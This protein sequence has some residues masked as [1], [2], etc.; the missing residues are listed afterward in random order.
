MVEVYSQKDIVPEREEGLAIKKGDTFYVLKKVW[1][2]I[3]E[4]I[5]PFLVSMTIEEWRYFAELFTQPKSLIYKIMLLL[6]SH[7]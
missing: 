7:T 6:L 2:I 1:V 3:F 5:I 4:T